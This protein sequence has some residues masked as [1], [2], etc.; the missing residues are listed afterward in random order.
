MKIIFLCLSSLLLASPVALYPAT[1]PT[2][3]ELE[4]NTPP[5]MVDQIDTTDIFAVPVDTSEQE[6][7]VN[8][9]KLEQMQKKMQSQKPAMPSTLPT[10]P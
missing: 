2:K 10:K 3:A 7:D 9:A 5:D 6:E 8:E 1:T 4:K